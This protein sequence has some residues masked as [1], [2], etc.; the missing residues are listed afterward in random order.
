MIRHLVLAASAVAAISLAPAA[1][2]QESFKPTIVLNAI[3]LYTVANTDRYNAVASLT[4]KRKDPQSS[5]SFGI[6]FHDVRNSDEVVAKLPDELK[7]LADEL[8]HATDDF[9]NHH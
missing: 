8:Q 1:N 4:L 2:A 9:S 6:N 7:K 5:V 3:S